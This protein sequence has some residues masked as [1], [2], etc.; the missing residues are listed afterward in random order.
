MFKGYKRMIFGKIF[1]EYNRDG[2][3]KDT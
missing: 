1:Y 3:Q 2:K